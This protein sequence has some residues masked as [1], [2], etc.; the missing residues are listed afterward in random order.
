MENWSITQWILYYIGFSI[1]FFFAYGGT[2]IL[3]S[4]ISEPI[5]KWI[6]KKILDPWEE[7]KWDKAIKELE[8]REKGVDKQEEI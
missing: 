4:C 6:D 1:G 8:K 3:L 7:R 2:M 5:S